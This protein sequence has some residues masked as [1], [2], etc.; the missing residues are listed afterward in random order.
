MTNIATTSQSAT[1]PTLTART[2][3]PPQCATNKTALD[4]QSPPPI[5]GSCS[6]CL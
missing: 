3:P 4:V 5:K 6:S 1:A 2:G